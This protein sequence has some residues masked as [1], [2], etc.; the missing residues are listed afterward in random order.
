MHEYHHLCQLN[1]ATAKTSLDHPSMADFMNNLDRINA[2]AEQHAGFVWRFQ[3]DETGNATNNKLFGDNVVANMSLWTNV[4]DLVN[5]VYKSEHKDFFKRKAEWFSKMD[6]Y[7]V[8]W[9][10]PKGER[11]TLAQGKKKLELLRELGP[12]PEAF[13]F[14]EALRASRRDE[15]SKVPFEIN[16]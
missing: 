7:Q 4:E 9:W 6:L 16:A 8:L 12:T 10:V 5:F 11:P 13:G 1:V 3:D 2:L 14:R 15:P